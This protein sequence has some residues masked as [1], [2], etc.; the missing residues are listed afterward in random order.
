MP[1]V[2]R[3][4]GN[5][6]G[7]QRGLR[8]RHQRGLQ[9]LRPG[10]H[11]PL[12]PFGYGL[13]YT[14]FGYSGLQVAPAGDPA[15]APIHVRFTVANTGS[16]DG[17]EA[18]QVYLG[19]PTSTGEPPKRLVGWD[20]VE[21]PAGQSRDVDVV[22]DPQD[23]THPLGY[24][25]TTQNRWDDRARDLHR[26][27]R[28]LRAQHAARRVLHGRGVRRRR[29]TDIGC[30]GRGRVGD[31]GPPPRTDQGG[32]AVARA[33]MT[34]RLPT[35]MRAAALRKGVRLGIRRRSR[36]DCLRRCARAG[37]RGGRTRVAQRAGRVMITLRLSRRATNSAARTMGDADRPADVADRRFAARE[38]RHAAALTPIEHTRPRREAAARA[39][40]RPRAPH[41]VGGRHGMAGRHLTRDCCA[42][43]VQRR[44]GRRPLSAVHPDFRS[45]EPL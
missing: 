23:S 15:T 44:F 3:A 27:C 36:V 40:R 32:P 35:T 16:R 38:R 10:R 34:V 30:S 25:D 31:A 11:Q 2:S 19:L 39:G 45:E 17:A 43:P 22:I 24:F 42:Q 41:A 8:R 12:F 33:I 14:T 21:V 18:A 20:K 29:C 4:R 37:A 7:P 26:L 6:R 28:R 9:G 1:P 13:S 5:G